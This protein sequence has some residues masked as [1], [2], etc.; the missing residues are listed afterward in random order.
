MHS[1]LCFS[2]SNLHCPNAKS[3]PSW[4]RNVYFTCNTTDVQA[5]SSMCNHSTFPVPFPNIVKHNHSRQV[6][7]ILLM[8]LAVCVLFDKTPPFIW[9]SRLW[10]PICFYPFDD[11]E[12]WKKPFLWYIRPVFYMHFSIKETFL[13]KKGAYSKYLPLQHLSSIVV[14]PPS[15]LQAVWSLSLQIT[16]CQQNSLKFRKGGMMLRISL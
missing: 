8:M 1:S 10:L 4:T 16:P 3:P 7:E 9:K 11:H 2:R 15:H 5:G 14:M 13:G 12:V 6:L